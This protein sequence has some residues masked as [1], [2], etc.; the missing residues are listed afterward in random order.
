MADKENTAKL[1]SY[2]NFELLGNSDSS[3]HVT[4]T[5]TDDEKKPYIC[6][7]RTVTLSARHFVT[8]TNSL[9]NLNIYI[10]QN[11]RGLY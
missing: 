7:S 10:S 1:Q 2:S 11:L 9:K 3:R 4:V 5:V 6:G 8:V